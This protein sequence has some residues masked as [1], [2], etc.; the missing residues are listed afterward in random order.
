MHLVEGIARPSLSI[1]I[2]VKLSC[3]GV[4][5]FENFTLCDLNNFD[6]ILGNIFLDVYKV[7]ILYNKNKVRAHAKVG[8]KLMNLNG[9]YNF[10]VFADIKVNLVDLANELNSPSILMSFKFSLMEL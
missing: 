9:R 10:N 2:G 8:S 4:Q 3:K 7:D 5:F 1:M 6:V